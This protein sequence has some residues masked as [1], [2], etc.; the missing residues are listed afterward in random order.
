MTATEFLP[1]PVVDGRTLQY[2]DFLKRYALPRQPCLITNLGENWP[3]L[4]KWTS[5]MY[6]LD[7]QGVNKDWEVSCSAG[8]A[9]A[10]AEVE[11]TVG[12][13]LRT[14][15]ANPSEPFYLN[16]WAY[17]RGGSEGLAEDF[18]VPKFF[19]RAPDFLSSN[20]VLGNSSI[21]MRW[22]YIGSKGT[23][24]PTHVDTNLSSAWLW[25]ASG[26]KEWIC[27]SGEDYDLL[28]AGTGSAAHGYRSEDSDTDSDPLPDF[29]D[30]QLFAKWPKTRQARLYRGVQEKGDVCFNPSR[31][32]HA[33]R[34]LEAC[35]SLT[36]NFVDA[37]NL[38][39]VASD[40]TRSL[41]EEILPM[42]RE[43]R[44]KSFLKHLSR[45]LGISRAELSQALLDLPS[46]L[47]DENV[48]EAVSC[49]AGGAEPGAEREAC[50]A[51][52]HA[53]LRRRLA[54][55][56]PAF[57]EAAAELKERLAAGLSSSKK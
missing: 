31:C 2:E 27:A 30:P 22:L 50:R 20:V 32:V 26:R 38:A 4:A 53:E 14:I 46:L 41:R 25:C 42:C 35:V 39:D 43:M 47:S 37:T 23:A 18:S 48:E 36:H 56:K 3:A 9:G 19:E 51:M 34:N 7:H 33:V 5:A 13:A 12:E 29:F 1:L 40:A 52:L 28:T 44:P 55:V 45:S 24:S 10:E 54:K 57:E 8:P 15:G 11:T 16:A 6:F 21:D 49:A 17:V